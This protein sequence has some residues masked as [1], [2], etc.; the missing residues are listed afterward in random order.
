MKLKP[1]RGGISIK[2]NKFADARKINS[3]SIDENDL[4]YFP[5]LNNF[6]TESIPIVEKGSEVKAGEVIA[7]A[8]ETGYSID[9]H[10]S[11][12]GT[13][14][15]IK[16]V[17]HNKLGLVRGI[18]IKA[19]ATQSDEF[20]KL[21]NSIAFD[22]LAKL[23][24]IVGMGG[25]GFPTY[26]KHDISRGKVDTI[27]INS[28]E[29]EPYI[30]CDQSLLVNRPHDIVE[31]I[32]FLKDNLGAKRAIVA[33]EGNTLDGTDEFLQLA[34]KNGIEI[35]KLS[36]KY[37]QSGEKQLIYAILGKVVKNGELPLAS[38]AMIQNLAT[39]VS[40]YDAL[41]FS[42]PLYEKV[43]T[44]SGDIE[45][46]QNIYVRIGE[47]VGSILTKLNINA[48]DY[49]Q[50]ILGGIMTG[51]SI[52][53]L[54]MPILKTTSAILLFKSKSKNEEPHAC[55]RCGRCI[56]SCVMGLSP[57]E[58]EGAIGRDDIE[59][60]IEYNMM[61]CIECGCCSY[62]CLSG[63]NLTENIQYAKSKYISNKDQSES[64]KGAK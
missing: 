56:R 37:P 24:G 49:N 64:S 47:T 52:S 50:I 8:N 3:I 55:C 20:V 61:S 22:D 35:A 59:M 27:I 12:N 40:L 13:V 48:E 41:K 5:L 58:I 14:V 53:N 28:A 39:M 18:V 29:S 2:Q 19:S 62:V 44:I 54:N 6:C 7:V 33:L 63:R 25:A 16:D 38:G 21:D 10:S 15:D 34:V 60:A 1:I 46:N 32:N 57:T 31:I 23:A 9:I 36:T 17:P 45:E 42:K 11:I 4:Y 51:I 43:I 30:T 26:V